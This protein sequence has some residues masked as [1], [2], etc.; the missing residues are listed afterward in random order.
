MGE[1]AKFQDPNDENK[2]ISEGMSQLDIVKHAV[3]TVMHTLTEQDRLAIVAF[4]SSASTVFSLSE[5]NEGGRKQALVALEKLHQEGN[6]DIWAG[7]LAGLEALRNPASVP[8]SKLPRKRSIILLTDGQPNRSPPQGEERALHDYFEKNPTFH[9]QVNT[10]G[11]GYSLNSKLLHDIAV[12]GR[13]IF[14]FIPDAKI[15][16]TCFVSAVANACSTMSQNCKLHLTLKNGS[17]FTGHPGIGGNYLV[18]ETSWGRVVD[19]GPL[20]Y[21]QPRDVVLSIELPAIP[22]GEEVPY[23]EVVV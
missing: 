20:L 21:G 7:L 8:S 12:R 1:D 5:M 15:V 13:G 22:R 10:F 14:S 9:C 4:D 16:G 11:F 2:T 23:L 3:K 17:Q 19:I 18:S 6:T